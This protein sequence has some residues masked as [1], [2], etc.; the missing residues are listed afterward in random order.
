M[1]GSHVIYVDERAV[2]HDAL[3]TAVH[4]AEPHSLN[5]IHVSSDETKTDPYG[6]QLEQRPCS[7]VHQSAQPAHGRYWKE[8]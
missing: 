6:R 8:A 7:V 5:L 4:G 2:E 3:V 1:I